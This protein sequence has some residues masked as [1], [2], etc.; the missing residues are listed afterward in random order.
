MK[1]TSMCTVSRAKAVLAALSILAV[2]ACLPFLFLTGIAIKHHNITEE[3]EV[4]TEEVEMCQLMEGHEKIAETLNH[5]DTI[6]TLIIPFLII[7][8]LNTLISRTVCRVARVRRSMTKSTGAGGRQSAKQRT[9]SSQTKVTEMLLVVSTVFIVLNLPSY[10]IRMY[11]YINQ[12]GEEERA[13]V[14]I[15]QYAQL[16]FYINF[17]INF[18][19]YCV[20][21]QNFRRA[22]ISLF[23]PDI[24]RRAETTQVTTGY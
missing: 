6:V 2:G 3:G 1:R 19:L 20:S 13:V 22:L 7:V 24:R 11:V 8:S 18:V 14:V 16:L 17:G 10:A 23:C 4:R 21:G 9:S 15:Q 12:K 5:L